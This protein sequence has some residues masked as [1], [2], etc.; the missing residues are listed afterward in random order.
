M[1][2]Q[3][4]AEIF[5]RIRQIGGRPDVEIGDNTPLLGDGSVIDSM[6]LVELCLTL[7]DLAEEHGFSFDWTSESAMSKSRSIFRTAGALAN[8]F[9]RQTPPSA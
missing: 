1:G 4:K 9:L 7:E 6:K 3:T 5:E 2:E 8:E